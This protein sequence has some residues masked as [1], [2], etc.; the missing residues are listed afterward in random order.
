MWTNSKAW[1]APLGIVGSILLG[2]LLR[3]A[4]VSD[5]E[6]KADEAW[7]F[8]HTQP[9]Q[10]ANG[11]SW[12]GMDS[13][14]GP[15]NPGM[16]LWVFQILSKLTFAHDPTSLA[17]A[18][19]ILAIAAIGI[20]VWFACRC[21]PS[22]ER[23]PW[24]WTA[25]ILSVNPL[26]VL[27]ERKIW[28]PSVLPIFVSLMLIAWWKRERLWGAFVWGLLG[29]WIGQIHMGAFFFAGGFAAWALLFDRKRV[30]W[31]GWLAGSFL[32]ALSLVPWLA[33]M[34]KEMG[35]RPRTPFGWQ[36]VAECKFLIRWVTEPLGLG[37]D[38]SLDNDFADFLRSPI[39]AGWPTYL[40]GILHGLVIAVGTFILVRAVMQLWHAHR[41]AART[42]VPRSERS[43]TAFTLNA[44]FLGFGILLTLSCLPIHRH[45]MVIA[46]PFEILWLARLALC[47][48]MPSV[49]ALKLG[50]LLLATLCVAQFLITA[51]FLVYV[52]VHQAIDGDYG[53]PYDAQKNSPVAALQN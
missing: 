21:V 34:A 51:S 17:R 37:L 23:E 47:S 12:L 10:G 25:A 2:A 35:S 40:V 39:L 33:Y 32:G 14:V 6:Y 30:A 26:A 20:L 31:R 19:Q 44:A 9:E 41:A 46:Y 22:G 49:K 4:W 42:A 16:S 38:Y 24:L 13:S 15:R 27:F 36:H 1:I 48:G 43:P 8:Q 7:T 5:M 50:R 52:H 29:A 53:V 11:F 3:L 45:Y 28:P 18:V